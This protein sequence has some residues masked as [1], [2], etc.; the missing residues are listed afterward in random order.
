MTDLCRASIWQLLSAGVTGDVTPDHSCQAL[1]LRRT[2]K[3][4]DLP[5]C[6]GRGKDSYLLKCSTS[7]TKFSGVEPSVR[8][9]CGTA[10][11][12]RFSREA[13]CFCFVFPSSSDA[14]DF[15]SVC[16]SAVGNVN[17]ATTG[18]HLAANSNYKDNKLLFVQSFFFFSSHHP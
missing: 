11:D 12:R 7:V 3:V 5:A 17:K 2:C 4:S 15:L 10:R 14:A 1:K 16:W 9:T 6:I 18:G 8:T 13:L